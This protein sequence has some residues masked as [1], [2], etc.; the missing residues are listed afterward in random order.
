MRVAFLCTL[1][2]ILPLG[3]LAALYDNPASLPKRQYDYIIVG[4]EPIHLQ[5]AQSADFLSSWRGWKCARQ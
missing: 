4:G 5:P 3:A 1:G 2:V